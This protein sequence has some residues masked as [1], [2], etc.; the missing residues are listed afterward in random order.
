MKNY[1][2]FLTDEQHKR[3]SSINRRMATLRTFFKWAALPDRIGRNPL[4]DLKPLRQQEAG[5]RWLEPH[6]EEK[7]Q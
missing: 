7:L 3:V 5:P 2:T 4:N 6:A 1:R